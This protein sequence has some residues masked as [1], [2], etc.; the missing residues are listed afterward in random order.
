MKKIITITGIIALILVLFFVFRNTSLAPVVNNNSGTNTEKIKIDPNIP[1]QTLPLS[2]DPKDVAWALFQKYLAFNKA[3]DFE[4]VKSV[5]Y[6]IASVCTD[7]KTRIDCEARMNSAYQYGS[8]LKK[9][10]FVNI[11]SDENQII[12][13]TDFWLES[14]EKLDQYGRFRSIIFFVKGAD[15]EWKLLSFS[16]TMGN[17]TNKGAANQEEVDTRLIIYTEDKDK[18]GIADYI[19]ECI[20]ADIKDTCVP[21][22]PKIRDTDGD[23]LWDGVEALMK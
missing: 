1:G 12:L 13:S 3:R 21:T 14:I 10:D 9:E 20:P 7:P 11:W 8:T 22:N 18:D 4:G 17:A 15:N 5:V 19:E 6:K 2:N 23:G 16:P